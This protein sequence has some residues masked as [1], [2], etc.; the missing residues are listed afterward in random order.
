MDNPDEP[1]E[2]KGRKKLGSDRNETLQETGAKARPFP[3][4]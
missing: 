1:S 3:P 2:D 4:W